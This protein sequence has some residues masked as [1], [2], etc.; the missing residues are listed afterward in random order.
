MYTK[1]SSGP[2]VKSV[3]T[4]MVALLVVFAVLDAI[5]VAGHQG[6][7]DGIIYAALMAFGATLDQHTK[8]ITTLSDQGLVTNSSHVLR[9]TGKGRDFL[10][11]LAPLAGPVPDR[12]S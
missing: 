1:N 4:S 9:L 2:S 6:A 12:V 10:A 3:D 11:K 5:N 8:L 7:P